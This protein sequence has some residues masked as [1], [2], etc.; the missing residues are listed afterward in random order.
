MTT[1]YSVVQLYR[2]ALRSCG[3]T[4]IRSPL[5]SLVEGPLVRHFSRSNSGTRAF[6]S[7]STSTAKAPSSKVADKSRTLAKPERFNPPSHPSRAKTASKV[8]YY[9]GELSAEAKAAQTQK[10]YPHMMP[11]EG[12]WM[13]WFLTSRVLHTVITLVRLLTICVYHVNDIGRFDRTSDYSGCY[14]VSTIDAVS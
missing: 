7:S 11:A 14:G 6:S 10:Q 2:Q 9:G 13:N 3:Y 5:R 1:T 12:S 4:P 8:T